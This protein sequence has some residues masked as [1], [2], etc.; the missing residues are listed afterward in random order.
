[1]CPSA[2][3]PARR[4]FRQERLDAI[5]RRLQEE[6]CVTVAGLSAE[7]GVSAVTV[8][9]DLTA[10]E[11][12]AA[13]R[14]HGGAIPVPLGDGALSFSVRRSERMERRSASAPP[15]RS[16]SPMAAIVLDSSTAWQVARHLSVG[17]I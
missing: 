3:Y 6:G 16:S 1:M 2:R 13:T 4:M 14:T 10:L 15:P 12:P 17:V 11:R 5:V 7:L 9:S 8:R